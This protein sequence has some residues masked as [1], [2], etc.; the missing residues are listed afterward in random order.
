MLDSRVKK[1]TR[2]KVYMEHL[3]KWKG[4]PTSEDTW[5][6]EENFKRVGIPLDLIPSSSSSLLGGGE[7]SMYGAGAPRQAKCET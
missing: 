2:H 4:K 5:V 7:G 3:I 6:V 1:S